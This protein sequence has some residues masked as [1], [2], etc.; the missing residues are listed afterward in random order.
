MAVG[1]GFRAQWELDDGTLSI[2]S[3]TGMAAWVRYR[4]TQAGEAACDTVRTVIIGDG[5][6]AIPPEAFAAC[7]NLESVT[8]ADSVAEIGERAFYQDE[9]LAFVTWPAGLQSIGESAFQETGLEEVVLPEA[10]EEIGLWA[11][12][13]MASLKRVVLPDS[14]TSVNYAF[15]RCPALESVWLGNGLTCLGD[16]EF[17]DCTGLKELYLPENVVALGEHPLL[18]SGVER[19]V[20]GGSLQAVDR[21]VITRTNY[22]SLQQ[23]VFC[24]GRRPWRRTATAAFVGPWT[25]RRPRKSRSSIWRVRRLSGRD[26]RHVPQCASNRWMICRRFH[27]AGRRE[28]E[29]GAARGCL[30]PAARERAGIVQLDQRPA[31]GQG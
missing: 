22:P 27:R 29:A 14:L 19:L 9:A 16:C 12:D 25:K 15:S 5:V 23:L 21:L 30:R 6:A 20:V 13:G 31:E 26:G 18:E 3:E 17:S 28:M 7:C 10:V 11:F 24:R 4:A 1:C 2:A 8:M